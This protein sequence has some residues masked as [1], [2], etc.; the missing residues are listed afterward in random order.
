MNAL[1]PTRWRRRLQSRLLGIPAYEALNV[2]Y[3]D[4]ADSGAAQ[5]QWSDARVILPDE[6]YDFP[7]DLA[8][9]RVAI[10]G[11]GVVTGCGRDIDGHDVVIRIT[12][13]R[14]WRRD[15]VD[16]GE[17]LSLWA[18]QPWRVVEWGPAGEIH[19]Q[20]GF[21]RAARDGLRLWALSP[22]HI[23]FVAYR[24]MRDQGVLRNLIVAPTP[25]VIY[26]MACQFMSADDLSVL[27]SLPPDRGGLA[28]LFAYDMLF[29]GTR[30]G[31]LLEL[32]G[33]SRISVYGCDLFSGMRQQLWEGHDVHTDFR[34]LRS[35][36]ER[37]TAR[38]GAFY[39]HEEDSVAREL[40]H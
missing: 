26:D 19:V 29:T 36:K 24:W 32:A 21:A 3:V 37:L 31:L 11:N 6:Y 9:Q 2:K 8:G 27:F 39:W 15:A 30:L 16:D 28:G 10:V 7:F 20:E 4:L 23:S 1:D 22:F 25:V 33:V 17:R 13:L 14:H 38:G 35:L 34:V 40:A 18:G 12:S 5:L